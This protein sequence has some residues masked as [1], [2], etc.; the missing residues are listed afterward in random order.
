MRTLLVVALTLLAPAAALAQDAAPRGEPS[1]EAKADAARLADEGMLLYLKGD[2]T[3]AAE[4]FAAAEKLVPAPTIVL[5]HARS[6]ERLGRWVLAVEKYR[7]VAAAEIKPTT[8]WQQRSAKADGARELAELEPRLP[9]L[10]LLIAPAGAPATISLDGAVIEIPVSGDLAVDPGSHVVEA[11]RPDGTE[12]R[13]TVT[14]PANKTTTVELHLRKPVPRTTVSED[15]PMHPLRIAGWTGVAIGAASL[16]VA[17]GT[18]APAIVLRGELDDKCPKGDCSKAEF[19]DVDRYD[20]LRW[21][22][23]VTLV[24]GAVIAGAG[25]A[26]IMLAPPDDQAVSADLL[27]GPSSATLRVVIP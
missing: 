10:R 11:Q 6:L 17:I 8:P 14:A 3:A 23:G 13:L 27:L 7:V 15:P 26:A 22:A 24:A 21:T 20:A 19:D 4:R 2:F 25:V 1:Q 16:F 9:R 12:A 5:Q 18:G